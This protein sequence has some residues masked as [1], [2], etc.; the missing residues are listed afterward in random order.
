MNERDFT[1]LKFSCAAKLRLCK[2]RNLFHALCVSVFLTE[3]EDH[4]FV[5]DCFTLSTL[6]KVPIS[7]IQKLSNAP[8]IAYS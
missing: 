8:F 4:G 2:F 5:S 7:M 3:M 1:I 6:L